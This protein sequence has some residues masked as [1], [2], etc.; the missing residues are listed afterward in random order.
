MKLKI[1]AKWDT[2]IRFNALFKN[3]IFD[4]GAS[5]STKV[6]VGG[7]VSAS[8]VVAEV[9]GYCEGTFLDTTLTVGINAA[10]LKN[11][12]GQLYVDA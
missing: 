12:E 6:A 1:Y 11:F 3:A 10:V 2:N 9:G 8:A 4:L 7:E 5:V